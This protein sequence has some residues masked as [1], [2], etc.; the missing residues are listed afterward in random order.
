[1]P[2]VDVFEGST[3]A[4]KVTFDFG[5]RDV[6]FVFNVAPPLGLIGGDVSSV[7]L[8][9]KKISFLGKEATCTSDELPQVPTGLS[10]YRVTVRA[11][12]PTFAQPT[13]TSLCDTVYHVFPE[14]VSVELI[15]TDGIKQALDF[16]VD[17]PDGVSTK[18][19]DGAGKRSLILNHPG[20]LTIQPVLPW[21]VDGWTTG[22][23]DAGRKRVASV[24]IFEAGFIS[25]APG[26]HEWIVNRKTANSGADKRGQ[27]VS[28]RIGGKGDSGRAEDAWT[29]V[30]DATVYIV[31]TFSKT[32]ARTDTVPK[33]DKVTD[34]ASSNGG[35][36]QTGTVKLK[37]DK[38]ATF[39][40]DLGFAGG[41]TCKVQIGTVK[42]EDGSLK[43][44]DETID[45]TNW[46]EI[47]YDM[48]VPKSDGDDR[49]TDV[50]ILKSKTEAEFT[51]NTVDAVKEALDAVNVR[52][53]PKVTRFCTAADL[54]NGG[55][56]A[57]CDNGT[58]FGRDGKRMF[59]LSDND[60]AAILSK[61]PNAADKTTVSVI[62]CDVL[63][64]P[65]LWTQSFAEVY[66]AGS[67]KV[68][69]QRYVINPAVDGTV[70]GVARGG[71]PISRL[72]WRAT[73]HGDRFDPIP[74][75]ISRGTD[76]GG[77]AMGWTTITDV[78]DIKAHVTIAPTSITFA[79]PTGKADYP[80]QQF[81]ISE[82]VLKW[83]DPT[84]VNNQ[85]TIL[86][87]IE[88][89]GAY[90]S[91]PFGSTSGGNIGMSTWNGRSH[92]IALA[93]VLV[94]ELGHRMGQAYGAKTFDATFGRTDPMDGL[95][96]PA[97][98][99]GGNIYAGHGHQGLHCAAGVT[100]KDT[101]PYTSVQDAEATCA[102]YGSS[103]Y[104]LTVMQSYCVDCQ[105]YIRAENLADVRQTWN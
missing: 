59:F 39:K 2:E 102:M 51:K 82:G 72:R 91:T 67:H 78:D 58:A 33:L 105:K 98:V 31:C 61:L 64:S 29:G 35:K 93:R 3:L 9:P 10:H 8:A 75:T 86:I 30:K 34:Y 12:S 16:T 37:S 50:S 77:A 27:V 4:P 7:R 23:A 6:E 45:F 88:I 83:T 94:H 26:A 60:Y 99:P 14:S 24:K 41:E 96:F 54:V 100:A 15:P 19:T 85:R 74:I 42:R 32:T 22:S 103:S 43:T 92:E 69:D 97:V 71:Y 5:W 25:P 55:T 81:P 56:G 40:I 18:K 13:L 57:L 95:G 80:G 46:R 49:I 84:N 101:D 1:L 90:A 73:H 65:K 52:L 47:D 79:F 48:L 36:K 20:K 70:G 62:I 68:T 53:V 17:G 89:Q 11:F 44:V 104:T 63:A 28:I 21:I 87:E 38:T 66:K 76:P